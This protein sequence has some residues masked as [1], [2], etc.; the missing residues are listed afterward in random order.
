MGIVHTLET[1]ALMVN[2]K[3]Y[4]LLTASLGFS[5]VAFIYR[6]MHAN[7]FFLQIDFQRDLRP[8]TFL[9]STPTLPSV[10]VI[11]S[12]LFSESHAM[13]PVWL[14]LPEIGYV[15]YEHNINLLLI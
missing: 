10:A 11:T 2:V 13:L 12:S 14:P 7:D 3:C 15:L 1:V 5:S 4:P 6:E 8:R 9:L